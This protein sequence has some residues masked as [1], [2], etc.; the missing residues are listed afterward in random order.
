MSSVP[1]NAAP[2]R[3]RLPLLLILVVDRTL[4]TILSGCVLLVIAIAVATAIVSAVAAFAMIPLVCVS[5]PEAEHKVKVIDPGTT[6]DGLVATELSP[7][8]ER[9]RK[10]NA[11]RRRRQKE[12]KKQKCEEGQTPGQAL[13]LTTGD[14]AVAT[15]RAPSGEMTD[16]TSA[17]DQKLGSGIV[18]NSAS[19]SSSD[20]TEFS[21]M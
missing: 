8:S 21:S 15:P 1:L 3:H 12:R 16:S 9:N 14:V 4:R 5:D 13:P 19:G 2:I 11:R 18:N 20:E 6:V 7:K 10:R 17:G